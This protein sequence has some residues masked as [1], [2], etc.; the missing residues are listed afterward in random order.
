MVTLQN[1]PRGSLQLMIEG[2]V[3]PSPINRLWD[4]LTKLNR[5]LEGL[6]LERRSNSTSIEFFSTTRNHIWTQGPN[7]RRPHLESKMRLRVESITE[8]PTT[9]SCGKMGNH[10]PLRQSQLQAMTPY[11]HSVWG[12]GP[13]EGTPSGCRGA[14]GQ[15]PE[16]R[17]QI[18]EGPISS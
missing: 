1:T 8:P 7:T 13:G 10:W 5:S 18:L 4:Q 15:I 14:K 11:P 12:C 3:R 16:R 6:V 2:S 17:L 9:M